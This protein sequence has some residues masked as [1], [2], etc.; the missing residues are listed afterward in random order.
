MMSISKKIERNKKHIFICA[1]ASIVMIYIGLFFCFSDYPIL[2]IIAIVGAFLGGVAIFLVKKNKRLLVL[3][4]LST[5]HK[6][7]TSFASQTI[8]KPSHENI[9]IG[10]ADENDI[11]INDPEISK[12]HCQIEQINISQYR[13]LDLGTVTGTYVNGRKIDG[14]IKINLGDD[15][16]I[17]NSNVAWVQYIEEMNRLK[18]LHEQ[19]EIEKERILHHNTYK[20]GDLYYDKVELTDE[21]KSVIDEV[22]IEVDGKLKNHPRYKHMGYCHIF[23]GTKK[24]ILKDKYGISWRTPSELNPNIIFD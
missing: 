12:Y 4:E 8:Y 19:M 21:Y 14:S 22:E 2:A 23:W 5:D 9:W 18:M 7:A 24:K 13:I 6:T 10:S 17:G 3:D 16:R 11:V 20:E 1:I 15:V